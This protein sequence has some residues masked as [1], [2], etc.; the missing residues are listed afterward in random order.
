[1]MVETKT[2][3]HSWRDIFITFKMAFDP[4][5]MFLGYVGLLISLLWCVMAVSFFSALKI[6]NVSPFFIIKIILS[7]M[8]ENCPIHGSNFS[9]VVAGFSGGGFVVFVIIVLGL[10]AIWSLLGGAITRITALDY[11]RDENVRLMDAIKFARK[12]FWSFF[13]S[14]MIP[15]IGVFFFGL[16]N[17][18]GGL[19]GRIPVLGELAVA[20]GFPFAFIAGLMM[21]FVGVI[22]VLGMCFMYPTISA[23]GSDAFDA[24]S[25]AYSY[26]LS[27]PKQFCMYCGIYIVYGII[28]L[29][30]VAFSAWLV[31]HLSFCTVGFGMGEKFYAVKSYILQRCDIACLG[32]CMKP[33]DKSQTAASVLGGWS[34]KFLAG[35]LI[36]YIFFIKLAV[37]NFL[38]NYVFSAKTVIYFLLRKEIDS[39]NF[40]DVYLEQSSQNE[41]GSDN[42]Q[43]D[44]LKSISENAR[45]DF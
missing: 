32:F 44:N 40:S 36:V 43:D 31:I 8:R 33:V 15:F 30:I 41:L 10:L 35:M 14:P 16:C 26:V 4:K 34:L 18:I 21:V 38:V 28:C 39:T 12:K 1:M 45:N 37:W 42:V 5:K 27:R 22:G 20:L 29:S 25:R 3:I 7:P 19:I 24:M 9:S 2:H 17:V 6:I 11:A 23:E 13:W